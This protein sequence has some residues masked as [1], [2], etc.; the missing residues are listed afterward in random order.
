ME[1]T[2]AGRTLFDRIWDEHVVERIG[3]LDLIH[4][5]RQL[6]Y[7]VTTPPA[8]AELRRRGCPVANPGL[9]LATMDHII[10][11]R[12]GRSEHSYPGGAP[13]VTA[14]RDGARANGIRLFDIDDPRQGIVH[15][16][17]PETGAVLPGVTVV[18][19]DSH[20]CT[21]GAL[22][23]VAIGVGTSEVA[24]VLATQTLMLRRP[25]TMRVTID[26]ALQRGAYAKDLILALIAAL[27]AGRGNGF[28][29]EYAGAAVRALPMEARLTL[30]NM[31]IEFGA[32]SGIVAPDE[33]TLRYLEGAP[34]AP[35]GDAWKRAAAY[36]RTLR[37][38]DDAVFDAE[39]GFDAS[40][41]APMVT[42]GTS[43]EDG[44]AI[45]G[46]VPEPRGDPHRVAQ[47]RRALDYMGLAPG[48]PMIGVPVD[49]VFIGAC[50][51]GRL[52]DLRE[53]AATVEG[54]KVAANVRAMVVPGSSQV[55]RA[56]EREGLDRIFQ[57]A[58]FEW[59]ESGCSM[60]CA[61]GPDQLAAGRRCVSTSNRNFEN[62]QGPGGRTHLASP[63]TAAAS[64]L[65]GAIAD[66]RDYLR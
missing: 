14:H 64:A 31:S 51:N 11:T 61:L 45:D 5:D 18:C 9:N 54:R 62:R 21:L 47:K 60:C 4:V 58:G 29:V 15:V 52:S 32:R 35:T 56:A 57:A 65:A 27:G 23:A 30:C 8:Y 46:T 59:H 44:V 63:A 41:V 39:F 6:L 28:A 50:T 38:D 1:S 40:R 20:T 49:M 53:A 10:D 26:G 2:D 55:R 16:V 48:A 24:H 33:A 12:P 25:R 42:W 19:G 43:P 36:W 17:G 7:E 66:P 3:E 34:F 22:G 37:S 13:F